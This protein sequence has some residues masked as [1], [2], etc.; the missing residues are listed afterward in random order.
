MLRDA[1]VA[2][3][4]ADAPDARAVAVGLRDQCLRVGMHDG[5]IEPVVRVRGDVDVDARHRGAE[6]EVFVERALHVRVV[7]GIG[8]H[9][10]RQALVPQHDDDVDRVA[11]VAHAARGLL[12]GIRE[13][14]FGDLR[15][16]DRVARGPQAHHADDAEARAV[17]LEDGVGAAEADARALVPD[18]AAQRGERHAR[19]A[20]LVGLPAVVELVVANAHGVVAHERHHLEQRLALGEARQRAREH[21]ARV[22]QEGRPGGRAF[23][24]DERREVRCAAEPRRAAQPVRR[25][26]VEGAVEVV[27]IEDGD[28]VRPAAKA[29]D[30]AARTERACRRQ[31]GRG[32]HRRERAPGDVLH[33]C[34]SRAARGWNTGPGNAN[35]ARPATG[36]I[37]NANAIQSEMAPSATVQT[38]MTRP[39]QSP[40]PK[41]RAMRAM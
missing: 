39:S 15:R 28:V 21:V 7:L 1:T 27:G 30:I 23:A 10:P 20:A 18:V 38:P 25:D 40:P 12:D 9:G 31:R 2:D 26:R 16:H 5:L 37:S 11:Q 32:G 34:L 35:T 33:R 13:L 17:P 3:P 36:L 19:D 24:I 8:L 41:W 6:G 4:E 22:E 29:A 14:Q